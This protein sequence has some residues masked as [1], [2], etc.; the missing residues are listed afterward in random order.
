MSH[1]VI[2][3]PD[4]SETIFSD[5]NCDRRYYLELCAR[6]F[7]PPPGHLVF[8]SVMIIYSVYILGMITIMRGAFK[9]KKKISEQWGRTR[10]YESP[11]PFT[12]VLPVPPLLMVVPFFD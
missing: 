7:S 11:S 2:S 4:T 5:N 1:L 9:I 8:A 12:S 3:A 6:V 10:W